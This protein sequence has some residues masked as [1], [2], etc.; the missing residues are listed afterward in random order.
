[1]LRKPFGAALAGIALA[2]STLAPGT[3]ADVLGHQPCPRK[4]S[5]VIASDKLV[6]VYVYP[7]AKLR[8]LPA[9]R[10]PRTKPRLSPPHRTEACLVRTG[11]RMTLLDPG[12]PSESRGT[13]QGFVGFQAIAG[14]VVAYLSE[15]EQTGSASSTVLVADIA[16]RRILRELTVGNSPYAKVS[17]RTAMTAF[18][19]APSGS[20][21][22]IDEKTTWKSFIGPPETKTFVVSAAPRGG[23]EV[24]LDE[25]P[26]IGASSLTLTSGTLTWWGGGVER[27]A[28]LP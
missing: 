14:S 15:R 19:L 8:L 13:S 11:A 3:Q 4:G 24:V 16:A 23:Q 1:M 25:S 22:W 26:G 12:Q 18:V 6:R 10:A 9:R 7:P 27:S 5:E 17:T 20:A 21:A 2:V 28:P